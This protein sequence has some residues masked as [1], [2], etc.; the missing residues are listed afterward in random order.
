[1][2]R[3]VLALLLLLPLE[4]PISAQNAQTRTNYGSKQ[5]FSYSVQ[6]TYGVN[7]S[8]TTTPGVKVDTEAVLKLKD[9]S[10]VT[11]KFGDDKGNAS[12]VFTVSPNGASL[13]MA[14][15]TGENQLI[16]EDGTLFRASIVS[17]DSADN[18]SATTTDVSTRA[19]ATANAF[20]SSTIVVN[21]GE[22][23]FFNTF[24]QNFLDG[25]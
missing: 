13:D 7:T 3:L 8:S 6:S 10:F 4:Q 19:E 25:I 22:E 5:I 11:N 15:I 2:N 1:M 14:G 18:Q 9:G 16:L 20:H 12:A 21:K 24:T 23:S 17:D